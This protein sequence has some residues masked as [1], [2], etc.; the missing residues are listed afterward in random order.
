MRPAYD[1]FL[2][3]GLGL[4]L[5]EQPTP[6]GGAGIAIGVL[7]TLCLLELENCLL[8]VLLLP[9]RQ[10]RVIAESKVVEA[11]SHTPRTCVGL[12][13]LHTPLDHRTVRDGAIPRLAFRRNEVLLGLFTPEDRVVVLCLLAA[14]ILTP[15]LVECVALSSEIWRWTLGIDS[16]RSVRPCLMCHD[17]R[18]ILRPPAEV[19]Q[20]GI[21]PC[22][23]L[24]LVIGDRAE[25]A[26]G[27]IDFDAE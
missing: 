23:V 1:G 26:T 27:V 21:D 17:A 4:V 19:S 18:H 2:Y 11:T 13:L 8:G 5:A 20:C 6:C 14:G 15:C 10:R 12:V 22:G 3:C 9:A 7:P 25:L 16:V 24:N